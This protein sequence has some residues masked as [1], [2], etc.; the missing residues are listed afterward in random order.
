H[1][2]RAFA[3]R[4]GSSSRPLFPPFA[5][6]GASCRSR[7][8]LLPS[9]CTAPSTGASRVARALR[10]AFPEAVAACVAAMFLPV[11]EWRDSPVAA[12]VRR[13]SQGQGP[14]K[15]RDHRLALLRARVRV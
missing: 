1:V 5:W 10:E 6:W 11:R 15:A 12:E 14:A 9:S 7:L 3:N 2:V 13:E 8:A 4:S